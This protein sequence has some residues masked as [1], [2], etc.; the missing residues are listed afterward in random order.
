MPFGREKKLDMMGHLFIYEH[1]KK[2]KKNEEYKCNGEETR[3]GCVFAGGAGAVGLYLCA[4]RS[5]KRT[6]DANPFERVVE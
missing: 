6:H 3:E 5:E 4:Y 2:L 1:K